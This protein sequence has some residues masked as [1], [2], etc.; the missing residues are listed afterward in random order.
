MMWTAR[1][2]VVAALVLAPLQLRAQPY[3]DHPVRV[4]APSAP[5]GGFD[6]VGRVL[7]DKLSERLGQSFVVEN[8]A[9]AGTLV[10]TQAAAAAQP[11]GY[12]LLVGGLSN[13][14]LNPG[15]YK[16]ITYDPSDFTPL[17][18][19]ISYSYT[20]I[21][22][23]SMP[24]ATL[25]EI[26]D[27]AHAN[28]GK[29]SFATGGTGSGQQVGA[30]IIAKLANMNVVEVAYKGAQPVYTDLIS[31]RVDLFFDNTTTARPYIDAGSVKAIAI[32]SAQRNPLL[33]K[34]PTINESGVVQFEMETWFGLFA[35]SRTPAPIVNRLRTEIAAIM[36]LPE[37]RTTFERSGG[38][39][40]S[41][42]TEETDAFVR[43]EV[44]K[45]TAL[46]RQAGISAD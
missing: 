43:A 18:L 19:V 26:V 4:I 24:Q 28:P 39:L 15:L 42:S 16:K 22:R 23:T 37:T 11:N 2:F 46:I 38:R 20:L 17:G 36:K 9:G 8:R 40:L 12:T 7:S 25:K 29:I 5:G 6:F 44:A 21:A 45:W 14:A 33:P 10:G 1:L 32:S 3:P 41:M 30:A 34:V 31:S 27:F 13:I 35:P